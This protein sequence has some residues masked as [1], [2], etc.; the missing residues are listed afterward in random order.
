MQRQMAQWT[1]KALWRMA[2]SQTLPT[3]LWQTS[4][5]TSKPPDSKSKRLL[6]RIRKSTASPCS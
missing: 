6:F 2:R 3:G 4:S 5:T 1:P